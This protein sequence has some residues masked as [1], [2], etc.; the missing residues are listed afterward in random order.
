MHRG[1]HRDL[2]RSSYGAPLVEGVE[3]VGTYKPLADTGGGDELRVTGSNFGA[4]G[5]AAPALRYG[6]GDAPHDGWL[7]AEAC[8]VVSHRLV[9]CRSAP[10]VGAGLSV[11]LRGIG[12]RGCGVGECRSSLVASGEGV[13]ISYARPRVLTVAS[14]DQHNAT[15]RGGVA[16][17]L[18]GFFFGARG[19][20]PRVEYAAP[21]SARPTAWGASA[22]TMRADRCVVTTPSSASYTETIECETVEGGG[23]SLQWRAWIGGQPSAPTCWE[24]DVCASHAERRACR[25]GD[26]SCACRLECASSVVGARSTTSYAPPVL[27][28]ISTSAE[29]ATRGGFEVELVGANLGTPGVSRV[30]LLARTV[31]ATDRRALCTRAAE[32]RSAVTECILRGS[33]AHERLRCIAPEGAG[34]RRVPQAG[35]TRCPRRGGY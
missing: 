15:T 16:V 32:D 9:T 10:G 8:E 13:A 14:A 23:A 19:S 1:Q 20:V 18:T 28:R 5:V 17:T 31:A 6:A 22:Q 11:Q 12:E 2:Q 33:A 27:R 7:R 34:A 21:T 3:V 25:D 30:D 4:H 35:C 24:S 29:A 26:P